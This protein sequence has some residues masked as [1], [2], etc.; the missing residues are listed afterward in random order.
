MCVIGGRVKK[1]SQNNDEGKKMEL[2]KKRNTRSKRHIVHNCRRHVAANTT[3]GGM[4]KTFVIFFSRVKYILH[5]QVEIYVWIR[6][7]FPTRFFA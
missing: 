5:F 3:K 1:S 4:E 7:L 2:N 6:T